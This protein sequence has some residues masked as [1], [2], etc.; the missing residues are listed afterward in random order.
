MGRRTLLAVFG[1][2]ALAGCGDNRDATPTSPELKVSGSCNYT[3]VKSYARA[4]FGSNSAGYNLAQSMSGQ[5][6]NSS[7]ATAIG[8]DIFAAIAALR[9]AGS[10]TAQNTSDA[11]NLTVEDIRCSS[12]VISS[13]DPSDVAAFTKALSAGGGYEVRGGTASPPD[14]TGDVLSDD[15][16]AGIKAPDA[17]FTT[18]LGGRGL[19]YGYG[20][21]PFGGELTGAQAGISGNV[22]YNWSLLRPAPAQ[23]L[24]L[25]GRAA[26]CVSFDETNPALANLDQ[27]LRVQKPAN[28]LEVT[29][30][31]LNCSALALSALEQRS[32][33]SRPLRDRLLTMGLGLVAPTPLYAASALKSTS[34]GGNGGSFSGFEVVN[35]QATTVAFETPPQD[36]K[37]NTDLKTVTVLVTGAQ[38]TPWTGVLVKLSVFNNNGTFVS[39]SGDTAT[40]DNAGRAT[41]NH[42]QV[43]KTGGYVALA[44]TQP[45]ADADVTAFVADTSA[46]TA[47][48]NIRP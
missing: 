11:A 22:A 7:T 19:F 36:G 3:N 6:A 39:T 18:W 13:G 29:S 8:F 20:M 48:F 37:V 17:G 12:V 23:P 28:I 31:S 40:T 10:F 41:Y 5:P 33:A 45:A 2:L 30:F 42:F 21:T 38:G 47:K 4:L 44:F 14:P 9:D 25:K 46:P 26:L 27:K 35:P 24:V 15:G 32:F 1:A 43:T 16:L 34:P